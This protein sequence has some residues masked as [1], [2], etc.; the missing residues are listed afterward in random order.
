QGFSGTESKYNK[1]TSLVGDQH[2]H[3][4]WL[5][6]LRSGL[7]TLEENAEAV[8]LDLIS[9]LGHGAALHFPDM[10]WAKWKYTNAHNETI[11]RENLP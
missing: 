10:P 9:G 1:L 3:K 11:E 6:K 8:T 2:D 7:Q 5:E 4:T